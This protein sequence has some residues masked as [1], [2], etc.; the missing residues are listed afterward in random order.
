MTLSRF[1]ALNVDGRGG[2]EPK[3]AAV[4]LR[5]SIHVCAFAV[6]GEAVGSATRRCTPKV[7]M[8]W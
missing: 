5:V 1:A 8:T 4:F 7:I 2:A 3:E 6:C